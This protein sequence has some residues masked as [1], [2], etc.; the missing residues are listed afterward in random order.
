MPAPS[1]IH[2][3]E[4]TMTVTRLATTTSRSRQSTASRSVRTAVVTGLWPAVL[5]LVF[6]ITVDQTVRAP[7]DVSQG[8][9]APVKVK[10]DHAG[11]LGKARGA[12]GLVEHPSVGQDRDHPVLLVSHRIADRFAVRLHGGGYLDPGPP[13]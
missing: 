5:L 1:R 4:R 12:L 6:I 8:A 3:Q 10:L 7:R 13:V 11:A 2:V 9:V